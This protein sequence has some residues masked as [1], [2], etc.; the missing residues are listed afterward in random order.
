MSFRDLKWALLI[1]V[2]MLSPFALPQQAPSQQEVKKWSGDA[3]QLIKQGNAALSKIAPAIEVAQKVGKIEKVDS[4]S[5]KALIEFQGLNTDVLKG[6]LD[7]LHG[8]KGDGSDSLHSSIEK[9]LKD[10]VATN[11]DASSDVKTYIERLSALDER[12][13]GADKDL[14]SAN[15]GLKSFYADAKTT[16]NYL[17]VAKDEKDPFSKLPGFA[18]SVERLPLLKHAYDAS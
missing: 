13:Q 6:D 15:G 1:A 11:P 9:L 10:K 2:C 5:L 4:D 14:A 16:T 3:D 17:T 8:Q 7:L 18:D 12:A